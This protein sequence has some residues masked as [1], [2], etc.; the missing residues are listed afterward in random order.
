ML[1]A[2]LDYLD[3]NSYEPFMILPDK[4]MMEEEMEKR[5]ISYEIVPIDINSSKVWPFPFFIRVIHLLKWIIKKKIN[6]IHANGPEV[7]QAAGIVAKILRIPTICHF[8]FPPDPNLIRKFFLSRPDMV[9]CC[10][11][12]MAKQYDSCISRISPKI[13]TIAV[14]NG[15]DMNHFSPATDVH[16]IRKKLSITNVDEPVVTIVGHI[17]EVKGHYYF[18][19]MAQNI[20]A[21]FPKTTFL[22]AGDD[23][24]KSGAYKKLMLDRA[25]TL[26]LSE[27]VRFLGFV[28]N[29]SEV[30]QAS[31]LL[32][33]P[34]LAEGLPLTIIEAMGCGIPVVA[35]NVD[36]NPEVIDDGVTGFIVPPKEVPALTKKVLCLLKDDSLRIEMGKRGRERAVAHFNLATYGEKIE[37]LY[38]Q[39]LDEKKLSQ[40]SSGSRLW[41]RSC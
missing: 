11:H 38:A 16:L 3:R 32:V 18:L 30:I 33:L 28:K 39:L 14:S 4:G 21:Q 23:I 25:K 10:S 8:H 31:S 41:F 34:S 5:S 24:H 20:V 15:V 27:R 17:S 7:Y 6:L 2:I 12:F 13:N 37:M 29:I 26:G 19:E 40:K 35:S 1:L 36:G 9:I 22:V